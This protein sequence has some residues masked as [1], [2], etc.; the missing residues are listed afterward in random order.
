[1]PKNDKLYFKDMVFSFVLSIKQYSV[2]LRARH[3]CDLRVPYL[4]DMVPYYITKY[5]I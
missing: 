3:G 4:K 2:N 1:M 5:I